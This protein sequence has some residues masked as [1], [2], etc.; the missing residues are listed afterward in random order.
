MN[1]GLIYLGIVIGGFVGSY[2]STVVFNTDGF[3]VLNIVF[4]TTGSL[5]GIWAAVKFGSNDY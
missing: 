2:L 3:S 4:G 1:K 5:L